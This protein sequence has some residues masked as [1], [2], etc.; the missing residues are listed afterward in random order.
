MGGRARRVGKAVTPRPRTA[1]QWLGCYDN[2]TNNDDN[3]D[4]NDTTN[5]DN[6]YDNSNNN[7]N[8]DMLG[9][10]R[11]IMGVTPR[12]SRAS[13]AAALGLFEALR[14]RQRKREAGPIADYVNVPVSEKKILRRGGP[15][16]ELA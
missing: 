16:G 9:C 3:N 15:L 10:A 5:N 6:N 7:D 14:K 8:T 1:V 13:A 2:T 11:H 12:L 4:F